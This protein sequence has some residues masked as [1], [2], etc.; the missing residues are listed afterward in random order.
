MI[1]VGSLN[2]GSSFRYKDC[3]YKIEAI[4]YVFTESKS[5]ETSEK[6][7]MINSIEV[8]PLEMVNNPNHSIDGK[9]CGVCKCKKSCVN[10]NHDINDLPTHNID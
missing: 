6:L 3:T 10:P 1:K 9:K 2:I 5:T 8:E 7:H 4:D